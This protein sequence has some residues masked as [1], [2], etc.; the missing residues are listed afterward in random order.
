MRI[1]RLSCENCHDQLVLGA[2]R[3]KWGGAAE[4][5]VN[6]GHIRRISAQEP[7][8]R[9]ERGESLTDWACVRALSQSRAAG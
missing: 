8:R 7:V 5:V 9:I 3:A 2:D 1:C 4:S 6:E